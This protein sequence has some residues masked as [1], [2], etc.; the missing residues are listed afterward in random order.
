[1]FPFVIVVRQLTQE[2]VDE[3]NRRWKI[4]FWLLFVGFFV[5]VVNAVFDAYKEVVLPRW[6]QFLIY[7]TAPALLSWG[8]VRYWKVLCSALLAYYVV[9]GIFNLSA[10]L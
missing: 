9:A 1:M 4:V 10:K 8:L 6:F 3:K 5:M 7:I 2:E